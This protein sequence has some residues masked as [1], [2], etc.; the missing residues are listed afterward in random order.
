MLYLY[1]QLKKKFSRTVEQTRFSGAPIV[2]V[3]AAAAAPVGGDPV[4]S[5][6]IAELIEVGANL[7][8]TYYRP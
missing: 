2:S 4:N 6:G 8:G 7:Y 5:I 1:E 3:A